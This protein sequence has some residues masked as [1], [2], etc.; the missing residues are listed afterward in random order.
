MSPPSVLSRVCGRPVTAMLLLLFCAALVLGWYAQQVPGLIAAC[1]VMAALRTLKAVVQVR[2][3]KAWAARWEAVV[4]EEKPQ[5]AQAQSKPQTIAR[6]H[7]HR[8]GWRLWRFLLGMALFVGIPSYMGYLEHQRAL[9]PW[10]PPDDALKAA[11]TLVWCAVCLYLAFALLH[12]AFV[13]VR[14]LVRRMTPA[15]PQP[16]SSGRMRKRT[17]TS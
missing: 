13:L 5:Q 8:R 2:R 7:S 17:T 4:E 15:G 6:T 14:G 16:K 3:Y 9:D 1:A 10:L 12:L 11:L